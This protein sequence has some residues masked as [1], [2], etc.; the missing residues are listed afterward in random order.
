MPRARTDQKRA[1]DDPVPEQRATRVRGVDSRLRRPRV[2]PCAARSADPPTA[3]S[4][5]TRAASPK[6]PL[7]ELRASRR[8]GQRLEAADGGLNN[9]RLIIADPRFDARTRVIA[10]QHHTHFA[11][12]ISVASGLWSLS[13]VC[14]AHPSRRLGC[15]ST[16]MSFTTVGVVNDMRVRR[17]GACFQDPG[18]SR[19]STRQPGRFNRCGGVRCRSAHDRLGEAHNGRR[20]ARSRSCR[21]SMRDPGARLGRTEPHRTDRERAIS[22]LGVDW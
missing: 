15:R 12:S 17:R 2:R 1:D 3:P 14:S 9:E 8:A 18:D 5:T 7:W 22:D 4:R 16:R 19:T 20:A 6:F 11:A 21:W 10:R 13:G